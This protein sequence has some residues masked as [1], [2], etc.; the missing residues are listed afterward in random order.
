MAQCHLR[1]RLI[2]ERLSWVLSLAIHVG[3]VVL[4]VS[5][6][7]VVI[8]PARPKTPGEATFRVQGALPGMPAKLPFGRPADEMKLK[9]RK[10]T[11]GV[12]VSAWVE[13]KPADEAVP[14]R[15]LSNRRRVRLPD[16]GPRGGGQ[17]DRVCPRGR[18]AGL[19]IG[20]PPPLIGDGAASIVY[21]LDASGSMLEAFDGLKHRLLMD[22]GRLSYDGKTGRGYF[23]GVMFY[24]TNVEAFWSSLLPATDANKIAAARW[25]RKVQTRDETDPIPALRR[26][27]ALRPDYVV[28]L[29]DGEFDRKVLDVVDA[30]QRSGT[31][32]VRIFTVAYGGDFTGTNLQELARRN[33]GRF[34]RIKA[35]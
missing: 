4:M 7:I 21:V 19:G 3:V 9:G 22:L 33:G 34:V 11:P 5:V 29:S 24:R 14:G 17:D 28:I 6:W 26:A 18:P 30:L 16:L 12:D 32:R 8:R 35:D 20:G 2:E 13:A 10:K 25:V 27:F 15:G 31:R 1:R 23:F